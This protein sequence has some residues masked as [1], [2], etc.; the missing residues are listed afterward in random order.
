MYV[1]LCSASSFTCAGQMSEL[2]GDS[3][4]QVEYF[5]YIEWY[6]MMKMSF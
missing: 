6:A 5:I 1:V 2:T 3:V 4:I